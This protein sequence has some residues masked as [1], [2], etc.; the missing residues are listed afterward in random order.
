MAWSYK[1]DKDKQFVTCVVSGVFRTRDVVA[2]RQ[3]ITMDPAFDPAFCM[4]ADLTKV[5][6]VDIF[7]DEVRILATMSP[8]LPTARRAFVLSAHQRNMNLLELLRLFYA[9]VRFY[10]S[11]TVRLFTSQKEALEWLLPKTKPAKGF[12]GRVMHHNAPAHRW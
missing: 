8:F 5:T 9:T 6:K 1:I 11:G 3:I 4:L 10:G 2:F 12:D 7:P